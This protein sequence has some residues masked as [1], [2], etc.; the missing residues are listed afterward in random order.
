MYRFL[1]LLVCEFLDLYALRF[2][3]LP[4]VDL[5]DVGLQPVDLQVCGCAGPDS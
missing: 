3:R 1:D 5:Y 2:A 4:P